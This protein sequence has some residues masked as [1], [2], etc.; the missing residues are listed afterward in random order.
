MNTLIVT[1]L[2]TAGGPDLKPQIEQWA[3]DFNAHNPAA[4]AKHYSDDV[5]FIYAFAGQEGASKKAIE[6]FYTQ[7]FK[8]TPD[9]SVKLVS[10]EVTPVSDTIAFGA[11]VWED[12]FTG[13]DGKKMTV[14]THSSEVFVKK[15]GKWLVRVDHASFVPPPQ[16]SV[17]QDA[18]AK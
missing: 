15:G 8:A 7:S 12:T 16:P 3:K 17:K 18:P 5:Q 6:Q 9:I 14:P 13:P 4:L 10:Y 2:L 1:M 11:G